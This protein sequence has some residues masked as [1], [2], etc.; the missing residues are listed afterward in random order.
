MDTC[1]EESNTKG[2]GL[3]GGRREKK[4]FRKFEREKKCA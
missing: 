4:G 1:R 3:G 2:K